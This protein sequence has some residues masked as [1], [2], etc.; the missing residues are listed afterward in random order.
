MR[1]SDAWI[2]EL[3]RSGKRLSKSHRRIAQYIM[4]SHD[5]AA[6][7]TAGRLAESVGVSES[8]VVRFAVALGYAGYPQF[9]RALKELIRHH[10]TSVQ[11][12]GLTV[13]VS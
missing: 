11:R 8:T 1:S 2:D 4:E 6:N 9:Q 7:L 12:I 5:R 3:N 13:D 10:L